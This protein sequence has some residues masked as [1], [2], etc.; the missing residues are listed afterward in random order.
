[1]EYVVSL[2]PAVQEV[3]V[4]GVPDPIRD[5]AI[6]ALVVLKE[7]ETS[8]ADEIIDFCKKKLAKFK[9]PSFVVF[10]DSFPKTSIGKVQK[11]ILRKEQLEKLEKK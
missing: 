8:N 6:M 4:V 9:V 1:V 11:N 5:E 10:K 7:G 3:A 2:H